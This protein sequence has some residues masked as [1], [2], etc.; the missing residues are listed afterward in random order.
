[1][2]FRQGCSAK[3]ICR[4]ADGNVK[5]M[6]KQG[7]RPNNGVAVPEGFMKMVSYRYA[8]YELPLHINRLLKHLVH[9]GD[10]L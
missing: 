5:N 8:L 3:R 10:D 1:M 7:R 9:R 4:Y 6:T 2:K